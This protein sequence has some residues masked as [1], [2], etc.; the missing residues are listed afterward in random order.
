[1]LSDEAFCSFLLGSLFGDD[2]LTFK[3]LIDRTKQQKPAKA[4]AFLPGSDEDTVGRCAQIVGAYRS[5]PTELDGL[6]PWALRSPVL[7]QALAGLLPPDFV[8]DPPAIA[9]PVL[10]AARTSGFGSVVSGPFEV[11]GETWLVEVDASA[12][13]SWTGLLRDARDAASVVEVADNRE[14]LYNVTPGH[15]YWDVTASDCEWRVD[16]APVQIGPDPDA[17]PTPRIPVP[18]LYGQNWSRSDMNKNGAYLTAPA[19]RQAILDAGLTVGECIEQGTEFVRANRV[20]SQDPLPGTLLEPGSPVAVY[21]GTDCDIVLG[22][23]I[24]LE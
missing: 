24:L 12:C 18:K 16:L 14:Y 7:P 15:Y 10:E 19:A 6:V 4:A 20:W 8:A 13:E 9:A 23:R 22:D 21:I 11:P 5:D 17:T 1:V 2:K 3:R